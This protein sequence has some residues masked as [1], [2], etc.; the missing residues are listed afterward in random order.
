MLAGDLILAMISIMSL[1]VLMY[2]AGQNVSDRICKT[3]PWVFLE[4][5]SLSLVFSWCFSGRLIWA[6]AIP[7][8]GVVY[9]SNLMPVLLAFAA[10]LACQTPGLKTWRRPVT[11]I[12]LAVIA[13]AHW[14]LP[15]A[16][17]LVAPAHV[18][19]QTQWRDG[20][21]LQSHPSTCGAAA[22]ATLLHLDGLPVSERA[23]VQACLTSR[24]GTE[25]LGVYRGLKLGTQGFNRQVKVA[26]ENPGDWISR[27]QLPNVALVRFARSNDSGSIRWLLGPRGD[28]HA[29]VVLGH[30]D[31]Q[32]LLADPAIGRVRWSEQD[33]R[34]RFTGDAIYLGP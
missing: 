21:C 5:L 27:K 17:P 13:V 9:W 26:S 30:Q 12:L 16:R 34:R 31:G 15:V 18:A 28:G 3:R 1:S 14:L 22:A 2:L 23:M 7:V 10:G 4:I 20:V 24:H 25:P 6:A 29:V 19:Q 11:V 8:S 32:W 33:F